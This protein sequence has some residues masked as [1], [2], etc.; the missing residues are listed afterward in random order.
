MFRRALLTARLDAKS[1]AELLTPSTPGFKSGLTF[2]VPEVQISM[3]SSSLLA[4]LLE[5]TSFPKSALIL[6]SSIL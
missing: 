2:T 6:S 3:R 5:L 1:A 4:R